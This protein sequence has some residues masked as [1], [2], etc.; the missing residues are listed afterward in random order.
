M[1]ATRPNLTIRTTQ[2]LGVCLIAGYV[3]LVQRASL[4]DDYNLWGGLVVI[5]LLVVLSAHLIVRAGRIENDEVFVRLLVAAFALKALATVARYMMAF[6]LYDGVADAAG[7][8]EEGARLAASYRGGD[9]GADLGADLIGTGFI[10]ALTGVLYAVTGPSIYVAYACYAWMGFWGLYFFYRAFR[11]GVPDGDRRR[12]AV[13]VL[14]LPSM[15]FW[16]SGLG[17]EAWMTLGIGLTALGA[18]RL[19]AGHRHWMLPLG[20]GL[21]ATIMVRPHITAALFAGIA[22]AVVLRRSH[23]PNTPLTP[24]ARACVIAAV[25]AVGFLIVTR[26]ATFLGVD[27]VTVSNVDAAIQDT[28]A[29]TSQ[30]GSEFDAEPVNSPVDLPWA[31]VSVLFRPFLFEVHSPQALIAAAEGTVLLAL[32]VMS[33][34][35]M[36]GMLRRLRREPYLIVCLGYTLL[37][38]YAFSNFSNFGLLTRE[39]VQVLPFVLVFLALPATNRRHIREIHRPVHEGISA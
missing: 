37:F 2:V 19:L 3:L 10:R 6:V 4:G 36:R 12:Y 18:A 35:R 9:F 28:Q 17:K 15:L 1:F 13:L 20:G 22:L 23:R 32:L 31:A 21:L 29:S 14:F 7:Y 38:V 11:V 25:T 16:P 34:P 24:L 27:E 5:P 39:R 8:H 30:G 33:V 26:A